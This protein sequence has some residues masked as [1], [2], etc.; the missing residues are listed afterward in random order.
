MRMPNFPSDTA[1]VFRFPMPR[2]PWW[3]I[4]STYFLFYSSTRRAVQDDS[5]VER[6]AARASRPGHRRC[7][8]LGR[9][10]APPSTF[11][12]ARQPVANGEGVEPT[13]PTAPERARGGGGGITTSPLSPG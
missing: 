13:P 5:P 8:R 2:L 11:S 10:P 4:S 6:R 7:S 3:H 1:L 12:A 9:G